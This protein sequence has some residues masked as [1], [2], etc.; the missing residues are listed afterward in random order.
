MS[1]TKMVCLIAGAAACWCGSAMA[2][3]DQSRAYSSEALANAEGQTSMLASPAVRGPEFHGQIQFR[4]I[5]NSR[6]EPVPTDN[7]DS[8]IGFQTRRTKIS[9]EGEI[10]DGWGYN[11]RGAF[12]FDGG[13]FGLENAFVT[14]QADEAWQLMWGQFKLPFMR[15][16][17]ISSGKQLAVDRSI[18]DEVFNQG[19][20]QGFQAA[21]KADSFRF[22]GA[23]S[24]GFNTAN[25]D[26]DNGG[27]AD[28]ALTARFEYL[29]AGEWDKMDDFTSW[30]SA[31]FSWLLGGAVHWQSGGETFA[32]ADVDILTATADASFEGNGWNAFVAAVWRNADVA[33]ASEDL[34]DFGF[35]A[36]AG[37]FAS[38]N[39]EVFGRMSAIC[40]DSDVSGAGTFWEL[41]VGFNYYVVPES[42]AAKFTVDLC[43]WPNATTD[44]RLVGGGNT[45]IG[46]LADSGD[47]QWALRGQFQLLF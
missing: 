42:H 31:P 23:F 15:E 28:F 10:A 18:A 16:E 22:M 38:D 1:R 41:A 6:D 12:D 35:T 29:G 26:F 9:V 17:L 5:W 43:A 37:I 24:D 19:Y 20:S 47:P 7:D 46:L 25:T 32:T 33:G 45:G 14:Y 30:K 11:I 34:D 44:N 39:W 40:P 27:E 21:Y 2:Q 36:Q 8:T 3:S 4:Y 13:S